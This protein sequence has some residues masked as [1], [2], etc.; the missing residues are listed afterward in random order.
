MNQWI[1]NVNLEREFIYENENIVGT[2]TETFCICIENGNIIEIA[3]NIPEDTEFV[4]A[5]GY[6]AL[7]SL[8]DYHIH[9]DKGHFGGPWKAVVPADGVEGRI[10][11][12]EGFLK[13]FL[14]FQEERA[15]ALIDLITKNG[16]TFLRV[17]VNVDPVIELEYYKIIKKVLENNKDKL[18]YEIVA[19]PQ[20]GTLKTESKG[21]LEKAMIEGCD[22]VGGLDPAT[23][24]KD[25]EK[26]LKTTFDLG[27][28][29]DKEIDI[30]LHNRETLGNFQ[31][32]RIIEYTE[33]YNMEGKVT[34]SH[35]LSLG[36]VNGKTLEDLGRKLSE[37]KI[38]ISTTVPIGTKAL[39]W[40]KLRKLGVKVNIVNDNINDHWRP[41]GTGDMIERAS[42]GAE[43]FALVDEF[44]LSRALSTVTGG[45]TPLDD[46]GQVIWPKIGDKADILFTRA[47]SSPHLIARI[48]PER[49]VMFNGKIV[50]GEFK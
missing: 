16:A 32:E 4:D 43:K 30:H 3:K 37:S 9:L 39:N 34:I 2:K 42:R 6:L 46:K 19:F 24:D 14:P 20:H 41:F 17:Q 21:L 31:I 5:K 26:S 22:V 7:P 35:A 13:E 23:I 44:S 50:S 45:I 15:Q 1:K 8:R 36:D 27:K 38:K 29:Y 12:E 10:K 49:V 40:Y 18:E 25:I 33:N 47:E 11:E 28:K 48:L